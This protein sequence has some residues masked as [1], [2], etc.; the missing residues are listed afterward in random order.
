MTAGIA[1]IRAT[2]ALAPALIVAVVAASCRG[3][4]TP[5]PGSP[6]EGG[7]TVQVTSPAFA[8]GQPIPDRYTCG[9]VGESPPLA[10]QEA[11]ANTAAFALIVDDP[12]APGGVFTH[13]LL[14]DVP[15][16]VTRIDAGVPGAARLAD[17]AAQGTNSFGKTGYGAP[18]PP[19]GPPHHY[20]F[21]VYAL[22]A[23]LG[24]PPGATARQVQD[25]VRGHILGEGT[26][27]GTYRRGG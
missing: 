19:A 26:L 3:S 2:V 23:M 1:R 24:L 8:A 17:G 21:T 12:D 4:S 5:P 27:T 14:Y 25:A 20:R 6:A 9:G 22:D 15:P 10:W 18:C 16:S 13:W 7:S 11:P